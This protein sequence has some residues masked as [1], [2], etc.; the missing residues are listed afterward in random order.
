MAITLVH[1]DVATAAARVDGEVVLRVE[2][3]CFSPVMERGYEEGV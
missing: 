2:V 1:E 3:G